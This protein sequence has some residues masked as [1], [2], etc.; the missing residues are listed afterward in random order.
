MIG[1]GVPFAPEAFDEHVTD[2]NMEFATFIN[3]FWQDIY[4]SVLPYVPLDYG[5]VE[6]L[7]NTVTR[8]P[9]LLKTPL[10]MHTDHV[11]GSDVPKGGLLRL[12]PCELAHSVL[13]SVANA[14]REGQPENVMK[15][16]LRVLLS[17]P[18]ILAFGQKL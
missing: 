4:T 2:D 13:H 16:W 8:E 11:H 5:D 3:Y 18:A 1:Y 14:L 12:S 7:A 9:V 10:T 6:K 17:C 15:K